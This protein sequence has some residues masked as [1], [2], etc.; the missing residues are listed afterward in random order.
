MSRWRLTIRHGSDVS[1]GT[2]D[3]LDD[4]M[5]AMR[6]RALTIRAGGPLE[7]A[8]GFKDFAP[9]DQ[10]Q[11]RLQI[12]RRGLMRRATAGVDVRGNGEFVP[13]RGRIQREELDP[14]RH[15]TPFD[16]VR[17]TLSGE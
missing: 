7:P 10:V 15:K 2:F 4:A 8:T 11:A 3:D 14:S 13:Y 17:E 9:R 1:G 12:T 6:E 5:T 16:V